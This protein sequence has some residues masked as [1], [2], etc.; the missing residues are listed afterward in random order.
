MTR[1]LFLGPV[2]DDFDVARD[3]AAGP[4]C[5]AGREDRHPGWE[6]IDFAEPFDTPEAVVTAEAE[7]AKLVDALTTDW[8]LRLNRLHGLDRPHTFWRR[9]LLIWLWLATMGV[10]ARWRNAETL[11]ERYGNE[12]VEISACNESGC[13]RPGDFPE[14]M[15]RLLSD[16]SFQWELDSKIVSRLLA[17]GWRMQS[18]Q[19]FPAPAQYESPERPG[20]TGALVRNFLPRLAVDHVPGVAAGKLAY[21]ALVA[22]L[23]R[24]APLPVRDAPVHEVPARF[25]RAFLDLLNDFMERWAPD[26]FVGPDFGNLDREAARLRYV[27]GRLYISNTRS[28][29]DR[30]RMIAA[31]ALM[32][33]EKL[34]T[35][36]H[37][38]WEG[39]AATIP[40]NRQAYAE[41]HCFLTWGWDRQANLPGRCVPHL[42]P[43]LAALR[44]RHREKQPALLLVGARLAANGMRFDSIPRPRD[45]IV[46]RRNKVSF[47]AALKGEVR[48]NALYRPYTRGRTDFEDGPYVARELPD[49]RILKDRFDETMLGCR[50]LALDHP[51]TTMHRAVAANV[52]MVCFWEPAH[53]PVCNEALPYFEGLRNAGIL[54]DSPAEAARHVN[55]VWNNIRGWWTRSDVA[56]AVSAWRERFARTGRFVPLRFA[57]T[58]YRLNRLPENYFR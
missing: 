20:G 56:E 53:W 54:H 23:P 44:S 49:I 26:T 11:V 14:F 28:P 46:Y 35:P 57:V 47:L 10:W 2:P 3:I 51:G 31:H 21:S 24:S 32:A 25:P 45:M 38:G 41:D 30:E 39:T 7:T 19:S 52:P 18:P 12:A 50:L 6:D 9:Y 37:G 15:F 4:W 48:A 55:A 34:A 29:T 43:A 16:S 58:L 5:F 13:K 27:K 33:G 36:Q 40:W 8:A 22:L 17:P 1:R 42:S